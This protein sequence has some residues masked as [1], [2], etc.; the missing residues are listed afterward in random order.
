MNNN[1]ILR[2]AV[3]IILFTH[4]LPGMFDNSI[5]DFGTL[6]LDEKGFRP[7]G[8]YLAWA[9]KLS[10]VFCAL[11]F[12]LNK[13]VKWAGIATIFVLVAGIIMVHY[14]E[15]WYV[16]GGGRNG[17]EYNFLLICVVLAIMFPGHLNKQVS[18]GNS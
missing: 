1:L 5:N 11:L 12:L 8:I 2:L 14:P 16:V 3:A 7:F 18:T 13:Y 4:S 6:Y 10:H 15:G 17:M 9:I